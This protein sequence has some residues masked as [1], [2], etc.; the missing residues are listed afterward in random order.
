MHVVDSL[1]KL[2]SI[3]VSEFE[4][5]LEVHRAVSVYPPAAWVI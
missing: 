3:P 5:G 1:Y 2:V 4:V